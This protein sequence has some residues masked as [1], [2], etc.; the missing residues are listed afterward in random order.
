[1]AQNGTI[2]LRL[3]A[4]YLP[5]LVGLLLLLQ[6]VAPY[7]GWTILL[8]G[9][10]GAWLLSILWARSLAHGL[11]L[12]REMR[13][14]WAQVGDKLQERF[15]LTNR[16]WAPATWVA[17]LDQSN[18]PGYNISN[19]KAVGERSVIHWFEEG[20]CTRRGLYTLGPTRM[21]SRDPFGFYAV[22]LHFPLSVTLM[23]MPPVVHLPSL[24]VAPADRAGEGRHK[25]PA[26]EHAVSASS[27]REHQPGDSLR[28][29]HWPTTARRDETFVRTFDST[30][31]SNWWIVLD[32]DRSV[33]AGEGQ[34]ATAEH[35][36]ILAASLADRGLQRGKA[37]GLAAQGKDLVWLPPRL[38]ADQ[39]WQI[40]RALA[41]VEP[42]KHSLAKLL[43]GTQ[44]HLKQRTG[45][46]LI[47][48]DVEG[49][50]LD[51]MV[52]LMQRGIV[53]TVLLLD[54]GAFGGQGNAGHTIASLESMDVTHYLI[55]PDLLDRPE[56]RPGQIGQWRRTPQGRWEPQFHPREL[57]WRD[58]T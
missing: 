44:A 13:Y 9:L 33:Q 7:K 56:A 48:P 21:E 5:F 34:G 35:G 18:L 26:L 42:G 29:I 31:A 17:I 25:V 37:V 38:S 3:K 6:L 46:V 30:P 24:D 28:W 43:A 40:L 8:V 20:V 41:L 39:R 1:M 2:Q 14:G 10:G 15:T 58:L 11:E 53:P 23:V 50:W 55:P 45:L 32:M 12:S 52:P 36:V 19:V 51:A 22:T 27:V 57:I 54:R 47:T 16:G 4:R 49:H